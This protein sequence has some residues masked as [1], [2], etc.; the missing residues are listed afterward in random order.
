MV[1]PWQCFFP[2]ASLSFSICRLPGLAQVRLP[3]L[4]QPCTACGD[5]AGTVL[6]LTVTPNSSPTCPLFLLLL[7][8]ADLSAASGGFRWLY[9]QGTFSTPA[10]LTIT[11]ALA[12]PA[13]RPASLAGAP[14]SPQLVPPLLPLPLQSFFF[15]LTAGVILFKPKSTQVTC[16]LSNLKWFLS[17]SC[18]SRRRGPA[19]AYLSHLRPSHIGLHGPPQYSELI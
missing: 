13:P 10:L 6:F 5:P 3:V 1:C 14:L 12:S 15:S 8:A 19:P 18:P 17:S 11:A 9:R 16:L 7:P 2:S 4:A